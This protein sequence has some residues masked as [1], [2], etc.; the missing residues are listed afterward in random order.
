[1]TP[2]NTHTPNI[3]LIYPEGSS[4]FLQPVKKGGWSGPHDCLILPLMFKQK[5]RR[6]K[7]GLHIEPKSSEGTSVPRYLAGHH[8]A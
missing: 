6:K 1:M 2:V 7:T 4:G 8:S 3:L 5:N